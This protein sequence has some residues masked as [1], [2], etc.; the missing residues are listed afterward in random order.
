MSKDVHILKP[1]TTE[2]ERGGSRGIFP[3][4]LSLT[5][6]TFIFLRYPEVRKGLMYGCGFTLFCLVL[7]IIQLQSL[8]HEDMD[9]P[10]I[11]P[12]LEL[13]PPGISEHYTDPDKIKVQFNLFG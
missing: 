7:L 5:L 1:V 11:H 10:C 13:W 8:E 6:C 2:R 12:E 9:A 4:Q 3:D